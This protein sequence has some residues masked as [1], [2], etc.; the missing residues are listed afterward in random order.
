MNKIKVLKKRA[1]VCGCVFIAFVIIIFGLSKGY[2]QNLVYGT[3]DLHFY[4]VQEIDSLLNKKPECLQGY[5]SNQKGYLTKVDAA[6]REF[7]DTTFTI[8]QIRIPSDSFMINGWLYLPLGTGKHPLIVL[9]NGGGDDSRPIKSLSEWIAPIFSHCGIAA[10][11]HDKRGTGESGG[12]FA[13]TTY[14]DYIRDA[15]NCAHWLSK[16]PKIDSMKLGVM[17]GSEGGRIAVIAACRYPEIKF[18]ISQAGTVVTAIDDRLNAQLNGM[19]EGGILNDSMKE[20]VRPLWEKS[21]K[22]WASHNPAEHEKVNLEIYEWRKKFNSDILP[23]TKHEMDS[24]PEFR[25]LLPTW[26]SLGFDYMS[27]MTSFSKKWL[28]IFGEEDRVVPT[29]ASVKNIV[30]YMTLSGNKDYSIAVIP[31]CGHSPVN[32][33]TKR[34]IRLE[35]LI[36]DWLDNNVIN[37]MPKTK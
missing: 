32:I 7:L 19:V 17:G 23:F 35:N 8:E 12:D 28:A 36:F 34:M 3:P 15:G 24:I 26:N 37:E 5:F 30:H 22:A 20:I 31:D 1:A 10:F 6:G 14:E 21:F 29:A 25:V 4:S 11:V 16:H 2:A 13:K 9:T 33:K 27:E 18:V